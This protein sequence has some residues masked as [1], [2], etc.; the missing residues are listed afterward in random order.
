MAVSLHS[1][2]C[3]FIDIFGWKRIAPFFS[4]RAIAKWESGEKP[5]EPGLRRIRKTKR[6][7]AKLV[8]NP[9]LRVDWIE[10]FQP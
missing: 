4:E 7:Q 8:E 9:R 1:G 5:D 3:R 10:V 6:L 2:G